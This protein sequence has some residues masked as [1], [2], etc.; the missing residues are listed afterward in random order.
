MDN[1]QGEEPETLRSRSALLTTNS[2]SSRFNS[3]RAGA[4]SR[5]FHE[6]AALALDSAPGA[7]RRRTNRSR[8]ASRSGSRCW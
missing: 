4:A 1:T 2:A 7:L 5:V 3:V 6:L 8:K